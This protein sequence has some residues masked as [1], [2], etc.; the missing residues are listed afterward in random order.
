MLISHGWYEG[1]AAVVVK[2]RSPLQRK[3]IARIYP[4]R[5]ASVFANRSPDLRDKIGVEKLA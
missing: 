5:Y 3:Y 2:Q 4:E 1:C